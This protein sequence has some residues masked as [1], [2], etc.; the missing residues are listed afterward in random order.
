MIT[1]VPPLAA[2]DMLEKIKINK[3]I[4]IKTYFTSKL[5]KLFQLYPQFCIAG[6]LSKAKSYNMYLTDKF[7]LEINDGQ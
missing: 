5:I 1:V 2:A 4:K 7:K 3:K 6:I